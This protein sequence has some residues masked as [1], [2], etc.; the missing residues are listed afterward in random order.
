MTPVPWLG[1]VDETHQACVTHERPDLARRLRL[2]RD[3]PADRNRVAVLGFAKQGKSFLVNAILNAPV[4]AA[5]DATSTVVPAEIGHAEEPVA[6]LVRGGTGFAPLE[7]HEQVNFADLAGHLTGTAE[8]V[9]GTVP[10]Q[11]AEIGLPRALLSAGL[12]LVD[13]PA[14]GDPRSPRTAASLDVLARS[15]AA[16]LVS[17]ASEE[18]SAG[19]IAF[20]QYVRTWCPTVV[21]VVTKID[22]HPGWRRVVERNRSLLADAG[23]RAEVLPVSAVVRQEAAKA[24]DRDLNVQSGFPGLL[25][26]LDTERTRPPEDAVTLLA[27]VACRAAIAE[28]VTKLKAALEAPALHQ[29]IT[30]VTR[31]QAAQ[32]RVDDLRR[33]TTRWQNLLSDEITDL[34]AD[35]EYDLRERTR[36]IVQHVDKTF[37]DVDPEQAWDEFR[38]WLEETLAEAIETNCVWLAERAEW[39]AVAV[40]ATF[41]QAPE[42]TRADVRMGDTPG[43]ADG[44]PRVDTPRIERFKLGQKAFTGLRGSYGGVLMFGLVTSLAGLPLINPISLGAGAAFAAKSIRDEADMRLKRRQAAAKS[45]A[46][47]HVDDVFLRFSKECRDVVREVQRQLRDH[48]TALSEELFDEASSSREAVQTGAVHRDRH[49]AELKREIERLAALHKRAG[50]I[51][52]RRAAVTSGVKEISA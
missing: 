32:R 12:A 4:C 6:T 8:V 25:A 40:A 17:D 39:T 19:E 21:V 26:W 11:R 36:K 30:Q 14:V 10:V 52:T 41:P 13:T 16:I 51:A 5:D 1:I 3:R 44:A 38:S 37:D 22:V 31:L 20:A 7:E 24:G 35:I 48:F 34:T 49:T 29:G 15:H 27:A 33:H 42:R 9:P 18:L 2:L 23:L 28:L 47:R 46:Q 45:A 50:G 43:Y